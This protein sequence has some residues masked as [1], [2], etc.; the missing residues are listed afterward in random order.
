MADTVKFKLETPNGDVLNI[1][2]EEMSLVQVPSE[3]V[4]T[5]TIALVIRG[6]IAVITFPGTYIEPEKKEE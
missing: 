4:E 2:P 1:A 6:G 3:Q 5:P